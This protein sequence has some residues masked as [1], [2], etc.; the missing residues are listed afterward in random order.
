[1]MPRRRSTARSSPADRVRFVGD[2]VAAVVAET[3]CAGRRRRR[4]RRRRLRPA[5]RR[6]RP[7]P[8]AL[9]PDAPL[10]FPEHGSNVCFATDVR[11]GRRRPARGRRRRRRGHDGQPAPGRRADGDQRH[12]RRARRATAA[13]RCWVSHQAPHSI[14]GALRRRCSASSPTQLRVV[15]PWVGGGFGP[16]A[17]GYVEHLVAARGGADARASR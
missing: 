10:L 6:H 1:M 9:A 14:H 16:K 4:G 7:P 5:A 2:I 3:A 11:R 17:A 13:S 8:T 15:C 12:R